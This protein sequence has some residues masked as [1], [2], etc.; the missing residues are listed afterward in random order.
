MRTESL[1]RYDTEFGAKKCSRRM[2][3]AF[4]LVCTRLQVVEV[5]PPSEDVYVYNAPKKEMV[6]VGLM[7]SIPTV[8]YIIHHLVFIPDKP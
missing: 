7:V 4:L 8:I 6:D 1:L 2:L 3:L 5:A